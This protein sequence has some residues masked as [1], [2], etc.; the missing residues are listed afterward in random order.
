MSTLHCIFENKK[1]FLCLDIFGSCF[2]QVM[3][4]SL[5]KI[6]HKNYKIPR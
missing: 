2:C 6:A 5:A 3:A 1:L 4:F